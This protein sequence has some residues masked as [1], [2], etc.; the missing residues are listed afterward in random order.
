M[1]GCDAGMLQILLRISLFIRIFVTPTDA[2]ERNSR[3]VR[4]ID[5]RVGM[6]RRQQAIQSIDTVW[7]QRSCNFETVALLH[8]AAALLL[9]HC[10]LLYLKQEQEGYAPT[11]LLH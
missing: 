1:F 10:A 8:G 5:A 2:V 3:L 9:S 6:R 4:T 11:E 7:Q